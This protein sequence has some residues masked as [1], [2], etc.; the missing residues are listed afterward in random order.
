MAPAAVDAKAAAAIDQMRAANAMLAEALRGLPAGIGGLPAGPAGAAAKELRISAA[1]LSKTLRGLANGPEL[2]TPR[3]LGI[4]DMLMP[5][6]L[7]AAAPEA[8]RRQAQGE[9]VKVQV[10]GERL[11]ANEAAELLGV[12]RPHLN[13]L[14]DRERIPYTKTSGGHRR[15]ARQALEGHQA[16]LGRARDLMGESAAAEADLADDD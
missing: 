11:T 15:I 16:R 1:A 6:E 2:V 3:S 4:E 12:S 5:R 9:A 8:L 13:M 14:L 7:L 10:V